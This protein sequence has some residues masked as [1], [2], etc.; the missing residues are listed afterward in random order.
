MGGRP[1]KNITQAVGGVKGAE[2]YR[3]SDIFGLIEKVY[4]SSLPHPDKPGNESFD[5]YLPFADYNQ[6]PLAR[7]AQPPAVNVRDGI[8]AG[9][10]T[11]LPLQFVY[12]PADCRIFYTSDMIVDQAVVWKTVVDAIFNEEEECV[13]GD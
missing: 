11:G 10:T 3:F 4:T 2:V 8:R 13:A 7:S 5:D 1:N 6:L 9:D 12:E